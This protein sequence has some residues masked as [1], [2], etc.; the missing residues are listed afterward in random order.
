VSGTPIPHSYWVMP[1]SLLA[2]EYPIEFAAADDS[3]QLSQLLAAG[4]DCFID[5]TQRREISGYAHL[6]P[7]RAS[8]ISC[9]LPD[10][11]IP[12]SPQ[13][14]RAILVILQQQLARG[15]CVYVHCRAGIGR[16]GTVIGCYLVEQGLSGDGALD[17]LNRL[18]QQNALSSVWPE[19][20][21]T[22]AQRQFVAAWTPA[23]STD[24]ASPAAEVAVRTLRD[25]FLGAMVG[26]AVG[27]ALAAATQLRRVG[28]FT[29]VGDL[30]GGG[31]YDLPRGAW[32]DDTAMAL[33]LAD[34]LLAC[35]S[36]DPADQLQRYLRW[37]SE[38]YLA[39]TGQCVGI[40]A[41][42]AQALA[43][44]QWRSRSFAG[45]HDPARTEPE[46]LS[47][48][49]PAVLHG[50]GDV[51]MVTAS[52]LDAMRVTNQSPRVLDCARLQAAMLQSAL[53]GETR[54]RVLSPDAR[55]FAKPAL[56][57]DLLGAADERRQPSGADAPAALAAARS[58]LAGTTS[59]RDGALRAVNL[60]GNS[61]VIGAIYGQLAGAFY[62]INGI[63]QA[64]R[65][66]L[67]QRL[68]IE[69]FADKLLTAALVRMA[70][71]APLAS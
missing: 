65:A 58:A 53:H 12:R 34:S 50:F 32:S 21:E 63:P 31:P 40:T 16:T 4:V 45:S 17:E 67:V 9:P 68:Q 61:D 37:K 36:S 27:D 54:T 1:G 10:H 6:L 70:N 28:S 3:T 39:A 55:Y 38:G 15:R 7:E 44:A 47:R 42:T 52:V 51:G 25:R 26:L 43:R 18:W 46:P 30:L 60:G 8:Y 66:A 2:G 29:S 48:V 35:G 22:E 24:P 20:P 69:A 23:A 41:S 57:P 64:W 62:G 59:F 49:A 14:M 33:C 5:L 71:A 13:D 19:V 56:R 11:D